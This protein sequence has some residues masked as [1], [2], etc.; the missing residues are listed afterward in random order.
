[1][2]SVITLARGWWVTGLETWSLGLVHPLPCIFRGSLLC[3]ALQFFRQPWAQLVYC[4]PPTPCVCL[5]LIL[6]APVSFG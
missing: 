3:L 6:A 4:L 1:M 5:A 2:W